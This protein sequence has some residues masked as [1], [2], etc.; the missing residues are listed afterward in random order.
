MFKVEQYVIDDVKVCWRFIKVNLK[1][2]QT[3]L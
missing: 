2:A 3:S 1:G